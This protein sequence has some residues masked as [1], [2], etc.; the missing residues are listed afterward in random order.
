M[1][2]VDLYFDYASP[3]AYLVSELVAR[4]LPGIVVKHHP[5]YLRGLETFAKGLPYLSAKL[6]YLMHDFQRCAAHEGVTVAAPASFPIDGLHALRAA[7]VAQ[8]S[9]AFE[10]YHRAAFRA[11]WAEGRD[12]NDKQVVATILADALG[13]NEGSALEAMS[14][15]AVKDRLRE[16]TAAAEARGVF[17]TPTF[18]V[19]SEMFWG[20]DRFDYVARAAN[21][22]TRGS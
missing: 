4:K 15:Q 21:S 9:G 6:A 12:L 5:V 19:G 13:A 11:A 8:D 10:R 2:P 1:K 14:A 22:D 16:A 7:C 17:G 20:H 18:F 3:W